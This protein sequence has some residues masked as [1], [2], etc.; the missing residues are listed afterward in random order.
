MRGEARE[1]GINS[2]IVKGH[3]ARASPLSQH[4][5]LTLL[6]HRAPPTRRIV[7]KLSHV[8]MHVLTHTHRFR[9]TQKSGHALL[10]SKRVS[11]VPNPA[12]ESERE[13]KVCLCFPRL[14]FGYEMPPTTGLYFEHLGT[15]LL[16]GFEGHGALGDGVQQGEVGH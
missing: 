1:D 3:W 11:L 10:C 13:S 8:Y 15:S 14:R 5:L 16:Y 12:E 4:L 6:L 9:D 2:A 7:R